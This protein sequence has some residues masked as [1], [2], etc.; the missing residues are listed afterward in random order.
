MLE[1]IRDEKEV[2]ENLTFAHD[3][4]E[5]EYKNKEVLQYQLVATS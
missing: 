3:S 4:V 5:A 1:S 2:Q